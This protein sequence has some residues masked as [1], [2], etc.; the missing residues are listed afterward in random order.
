[1]TVSEKSIYI[2]GYI[3]AL[4]LDPDSAVAKAIK[5]VCDFCGELAAELQRQYVRAGGFEKAIDD[6]KEYVDA[7][8]SDLCA[9]EDVLLPPDDDEDPDDVDEAEDEAEADDAGEEAEA[10]GGAEAAEAEDAE[11]AGEEAE[12]DD[13]GDASD[14]DD[15]DDEDVYQ[16]TC[17]KCG[18]EC[19]F[20]E[21]DI[22]DN[23]SVICPVCGAPIEDLGLKEVAEDGD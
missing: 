3:D 19:L 18:S 6:M 22:L 15:D 17:P 1:M 12:A 14:G 8:D 23:D 5:T 2:K 9:I 10:D 4:S 16:T 21:D 13:A 7:I 11:D 20:T